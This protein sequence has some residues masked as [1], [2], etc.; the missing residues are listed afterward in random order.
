M[1]LMYFCF[2]GLTDVLVQTEHNRLKWLD[3][4]QQLAEAKKTI[5][6]LRAQNEELECK[7]KRLRTAFGMELQKGEEK[8]KECAKLRKI[9]T[10]IRECITDENRFSKEVNNLGI[11]TITNSNSHMSSLSTNSDYHSGSYRDFMLNIINNSDQYLNRQ[12]KISAGFN[13]RTSKHDSPLS[14]DEEELQFDK[15][16]DDIHVSCTNLRPREHYRDHAQPT[17]NNVVVNSK[18]QENANDLTYLAGTL[19]RPKSPQYSSATHTATT[20]PLAG[21]PFAPINEEDGPISSKYSRNSSSPIQ[22]TTSDNCFG[23]NEESNC[24]EV[25]VENCNPNRRFETGQ[26]DTAEQDQSTYATPKSPKTKSYLPPVS[27]TMEARRFLI[28]SASTK[29]IRI[30][31]TRLDKRPHN[32]LQKK[33]FKPMTCVPCGKSINFCSKALVCLDCRTTCHITCQPQLGL[34]CIPHYT[35]KAISRNGNHMLMISDFIAPDTRPFV[36]SIL[37]HCC[38]EIEKRS[39]GEEGI[40]RKCGSDR[41]VRELKSKFLLSKCGPPNIKKVDVH[42]LCGVV[43]MFLR[44]LDDPLITRYM[45]QDFVVATG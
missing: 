18:L 13:R 11:T 29:K 1:S 20:Y 37:V 17:T 31:L 19:K 12:R 44:D 5:K 16:E 26:C 7:L 30:D 27:G 45:L 43:K 3:D 38:N 6:S 32:L 41:E 36:P 22:S 9:V 4:R 39:L 25:E 42:V 34:P 14:S 40:Y 35:P 10:L 28:R 23:D 2:A 8:D 33:I 15:T 21:K 24:Q